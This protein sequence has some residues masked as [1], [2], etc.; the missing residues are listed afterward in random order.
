MTQ[1]AIVIFCIMDWNQS[2]EMKKE[3]WNAIK[4]HL[5]SKPIFIQNDNDIH[6]MCPQSSAIW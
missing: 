3:N 1:I 6:E 4:T 2:A 5:N